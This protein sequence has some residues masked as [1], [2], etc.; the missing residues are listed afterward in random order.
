MPLL[1]LKL[2]N[3]IKEVVVNNLRQP[4]LYENHLLVLYVIYTIL[5]FY[6]H[7][8]PQDHWMYALY[9]VEYLMRYI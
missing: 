6:L 2:N 5:S 3:Y 4:L 9:N 8:N 7:K 1:K